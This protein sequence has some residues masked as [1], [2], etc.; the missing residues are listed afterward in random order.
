MESV[1]VQW[2]YQEN[3]RDFLPRL[4]AAITHVTV[5]PDGALFCTS[6]GDNSKLAPAGVLQPARKLSH[7]Q[8]YLL[9]PLSIAAIIIIPC[10]CL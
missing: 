5:S 3:Q 1:L 9:F 2:K 4:G 8:N 6:H 7:P 10:L